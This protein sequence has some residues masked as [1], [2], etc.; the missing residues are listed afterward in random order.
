MSF[1]CDDDLGG[2]DEAKLA[3][4]GR[5][6]ESFGH[7]LEAI[8]PTRNEWLQLHTTRGHELYGRLEE[9]TGE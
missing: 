7:L 1:W 8:E 9:P 2:I 3:F 4:S 6:Q 5:A